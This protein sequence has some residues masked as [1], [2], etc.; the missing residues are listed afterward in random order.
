MSTRSPGPPSKR[1][2]LD[3]NHPLKDNKVSEEPQVQDEELPATSDED[4]DHQCSICLQPIV[5]RT[6]LP[7]CSHEFCFD[8]LLLW[9][10]QSR[11]CPL[12]S[13]F[14]GGYLIHSIR[15][16]YGFRKHYLAPL[17]TSPVAERPP[18][19]SSQVEFST[20]RYRSARERERDRR[21]REEREET[22]KLQRSI[23]KRRLM[24]E[25]D[26]YAKHVASNSFTRYRPYPTPAQFASSTEL[27]SRTT[28][29]LRRE[30]QVWDD[31]D[32][33]FLTTFIISLM[34]SIDIRSES[35]VKLLAEFLDMDAPYI[36]GGRHVNAEHFAH[37]VYSYVRSPF[38]DLFVY[39]TVV[40]Y[41]TPP[42]SFSSSNTQ[43]NR[44]RANSRSRSR[45]RSRRI[46]SPSPSERTRSVS[47]SPSG[48]R[49]SSSRERGRRD[50]STDRSRHGKQRDSH[51]VYNHGSAENYVEPPSRDHKY[52]SITNE[53]S[54]DSS[55]RVTKSVKGKER[56]N[57]SHVRNFPDPN[58]RHTSSHASQTINGQG[59]QRP[60]PPSEAPVV[61]KQLISDRKRPPRNRTLLES[62]QT[63]L[64]L[65]SKSHPT[66]NETLPERRPHRQDIPRDGSSHLR[67]SCNAPSLLARMSDVSQAVALVPAPV[68]V[69]SSNN[70]TDVLPE[71]PRFEP[72]AGVQ[73][74]MSAPQIMAR[75]RARLA[76]NGEPASKFLGAVQSQTENSSSSHSNRRQDTLPVSS[77]AIANI[78]PA[79]DTQHHGGSL[80]TTVPL[81]D[82]ASSSRGLDP[83]SQNKRMTKAGNHGTDN[84]ADQDKSAVHQVPISGMSANLPHQLSPKDVSHVGPSSSMGDTSIDNTNS[85]AKPTH[86]KDM[87]HP[88]AM[89]ARTRLLSRLEEEKH[90][91]RRSSPTTIKD[92]LPEMSNPDRNF[93]ERGS[94]S[95][96]PTTEVPVASEIDPHVLEAKLRT[97]AQLRVRLAAEKRSSRS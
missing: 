91:A 21:V 85:L 7:T 78:R 43:Q 42:D 89:D 81:I 32:V 83:Y 95:L 82:T 13:Q 4:F 69:M 46:R 41:D 80:N 79:Q 92:S 38:R 66:G 35:A 17:R 51:D 10:E 71:F 56:A 34:K 73:T 31:L 33:E 77:G 39:D 75:T 16:R 58:L 44:W 23:E 74:R 67:E 18:I 60:L 65:G 45:S 5:D 6:V 36:E 90:Q 9:S 37:E 94:R 2:K 63:H 40:Q 97:R 70:V 52:T 20:R 26:L 8:C 12:C 24:Y 64:T 86:S 11:R 96:P 68:S 48:R 47:W 25:H 3:P 30:L 1:L 55:Q 93:R 57:E 28:T 84:G 76:K 19:R 29:F 54:Q 22:D 87:S 88:P 53:D 59:D 14:I 72:P 27:I 15:S 49:Y 61:P 50:N 62:V